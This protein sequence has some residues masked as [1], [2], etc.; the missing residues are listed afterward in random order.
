MEKKEKAPKM[1]TC[2]HCGAE[3]AAG[4]KT[5][6]KC[7]GKN[8]KPIYKRAWFIILVVLVVIG[9]ISGMG[10]SD[11]GSNTSSTDTESSTEQK[12]EYKKYDVGELMND[13]EENAS[14]ASDKYTDQYVEITGRL[15]N[16]DADCA[17]IDVV[18]SSD[19][20]AILGVQCYTRY[21]DD[22]KAKVKELSKDQIVTVKGKITDVGEV[23][24]YSLDIEKIK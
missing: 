2:K 12:I 5:C 6:P 1:V 7:G 14:K 18:D 8:K 3:I 20:W 22:I 10:S 15:S 17:Y 16:I 13:L 4:A 19:E 24:G 9:G 11:T 23:M 21:D